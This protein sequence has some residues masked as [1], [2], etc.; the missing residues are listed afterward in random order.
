M[1]ARM[2]R[3]C[4]ARTGR[5]KNCRKLRGL[6]DLVMPGCRERN[7]YVL[8][9][10]QRLWRDAMFALSEYARKSQ[11]E[12]GQL[13]TYLSRLG[14]GARPKTV[15]AGL[16]GNNTE[17]LHAMQQRGARHSEPNRGAAVSAYNPIHLPEHFQ[18]MSALGILE[19]AVG[20]RR[21]LILV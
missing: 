20:R 12:G 19:C 21:G 4:D 16:F 15:L 14:S 1:S 10:G 5:G 9:V 17:F 7:G 8:Q 13:Q 3:S 11:R 18:N 2:P 6:K